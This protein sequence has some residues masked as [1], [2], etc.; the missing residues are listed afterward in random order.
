M[1]VPGTEGSDDKGYWGQTPDQPGGVP[2]FR[3]SSKKNRLSGL[4]FFCGTKSPG[5]T[6]QA[7]PAVYR[8]LLLLQILVFI[9]PL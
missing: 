5:D 7:D 1:I 8:V 4:F 3:C 6:P 9:T 2:G